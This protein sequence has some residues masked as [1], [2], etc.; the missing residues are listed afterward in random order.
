MGFERLVLL[1][2]RYDVVLWSGVLKALL[3]STCPGRDGF[4]AYLDQI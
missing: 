4:G 1:A 3:E 2:S